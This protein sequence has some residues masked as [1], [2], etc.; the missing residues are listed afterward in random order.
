MELRS[1][2]AVQILAAAF[3]KNLSVN[4]T[5]KQ[6]SKREIRINALMNYAVELG[7]RSNGLHFSNDGHS[8]A[9]CFDPT[10][11][12]SGLSATLAQ[13]KLV[14]KAIG[15]NRLF[16]MLKKDKAIASRRPA[17]PHYYLMLVGTDPQHHG[18][19]S[20]SQ[21]LD[22]LL[23]TAAKEGKEVYLETSVD[24]NIP[25][26]EKRG[27]AVFDTW[28]VREGYFIRFMKWSSHTK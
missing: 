13:L 2:N 26:Y 19:G 4:D 20:G 12:K 25:F 18:K 11:S 6:D 21:L 23:Q 7:Q 16:Y 22:Q 9:V 10:Q 24:K 14:H 15:W 1:N 28:L 27:F 17:Y 8:V 3:D 5:I